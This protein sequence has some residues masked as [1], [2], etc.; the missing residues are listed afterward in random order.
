MLYTARAT[1]RQHN[2]HPYLIKWT[3]LPEMEKLMTVNKTTGT[4][5]PKTKHCVKCGETKPSAQFKRRLSLAQSRAV[6]RNPNITTNYI[7]DSKLCKLCQPKRKPPRLLTIKE[8]RTRISNGDIHS[9]TGEIKIKQM[10]EAIPK[11]RSKVMK[12]YWQ[13]KKTKPIEELKVALAQQVAKYANRYNALKS[14]NPQHADLP[15][16]KYS[17]DEAKRVR[18]SLLSRARSGEVIDPTIKI[19]ELI[20]RRKV[21]V[22]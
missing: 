20:K 19:S 15:Q 18:D 9:V 3:H 21:G 2:R 5:V 7:A 10:Q 12:E 22:A 13:N 1:W 8:I 16:Y 11:R 4:N 14:Y 6:L 17:Y